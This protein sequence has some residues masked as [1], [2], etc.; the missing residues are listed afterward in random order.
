MGDIVSA[1]EEIL[2][3]ARAEAARRSAPMPALPPGSDAFWGGSPEG[4]D[5]FFAAGGGL[6][7]PDPD[8]RIP[9][10]A[11][12]DLAVKWKRMRRTAPSGATAPREGVLQERLQRASAVNSGFAGQVATRWQA[13]RNWSGAIIGAQDGTRFTAVTARWTVPDAKPQGPGAP[14]PIPGSSPTDPLSRRVSVWIGL[15]G[16]R[17]V[18]G[19]LPQIGTTTAE[20]FKGK[21]RWVEAYAWAQWW[22]LGRNYG[23]VVFTGFAVRPGDEVSCWLAL[24]SPERVVMCIRNETR[25]TEDSVA[26]QSGP[27]GAGRGRAG[28][29]Q[30]HA[31]PAPVDGMA[32]V[33]CVE[34]PTV[35]GRTDK[36][37]LPDFGRVEFR[38][39]IAGAATRS[40]GD[41]APY[42]A[43]DSLRPLD[44]PHF[45]R[46]VDRRGTPAVARRISVP[47]RGPTRDS[48]T[49]RFRG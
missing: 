49:V 38:D 18:A 34:R 36:F 28:L 1:V 6:P 29:A 40:R 5:A 3:A 32:A 14:P 44:R 48:L 22:V 39:C 46:M 19:S 27:I 11:W 10:A 24:H 8:H 15:D 23:E 12:M 2:A 17:D 42:A 41:V 30:L 21:E 26:W 35:M 9:G 43:V 25:G 47:E 31:Q 45:I 16:H 20:M 33:W 4:H 13:S 7:W 37:P